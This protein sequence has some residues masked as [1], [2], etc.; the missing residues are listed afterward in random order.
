MDF[1]LN[2]LLITLTLPNIVNPGPI[3]ELNVLYH[4]VGVFVNLRDKSPSPQLFTN[5]ILDFQGHIFHE[6]P[7]IVILNET[8]L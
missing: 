6:K 3:N 8:W 1:S 5:K 2:F 4:N 7:D